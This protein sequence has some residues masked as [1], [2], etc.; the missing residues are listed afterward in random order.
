MIR[1]LKDIKK[2]EFNIEEF[3]SI[4]DDFIKDLYRKTHYQKVLGYFSL[5][6]GLKD[7][8]TYPEPKVVIKMILLRYLNRPQA[9]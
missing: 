5:I 6:K 9:K 3:K 7:G 2:K 8:L 4:D 1:K